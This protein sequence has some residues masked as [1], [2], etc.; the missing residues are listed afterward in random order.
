[1]FFT[2]KIKILLVGGTGYI[3]NHFHK[4]FNKNKF[5]TY[6]TGTS[7]K[8]DDSY[9][10]IDFNNPD[11]FQKIK[12]LKFD[13]VILLTASLNSLNT[14][15]LTH[16]DLYFNS[17]TYSNF[18]QFLID[19]KITSKIIYMSSMTVYDENGISP[20]KEENKTLPPNL[21]G[22][23]KLL[24]ENITQFAC[25]NNPLSGA[26]LRTPGVYG[27]ERNGGIIYNSIKELKNGNLLNYDF[28]DLKY[29]ETI[30]IDDLMK[31]VE[32]FITN[33]SWDKKIEI[34]NICYGQKMDIEQTLSFIS[35]SISHKGVKINNPP[36]EFY[37][38]NNKINTIVNLQIDSYLSLENY[39][40]R[41]K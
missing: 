9:Y 19:N 7:D 29:W 32:L 17:I 3:G 34:F 8:T 18:L 31:W 40:K 13:L 26:I 20:I 1:M 21:Y 27:G 28:Q 11:T 30:N 39:L 6:I 23:S 33:Y 22:L 41:V 25:Q 10:Y 37:M 36:K 14:I 35:N 16:N 2:M 12:N 38:S 15:N 24:A 4:N 5:K